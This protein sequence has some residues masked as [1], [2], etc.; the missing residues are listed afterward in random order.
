MSPAIRRATG[1]DAQAL[2]DIGRRSFVEA[3][4]HLYGAEDLEAF[5]K[6]SHA[7]DVYARYLADPAYALWLLDD[8]GHVVGYAL[9]GPAGLPHPEVTSADGELKRLYVLSAAQN[10]G[11]GGQL[12]QAAMDWLQ[13][14][15]PRS[16][17][18]SVWSE[19]LG[20]QRFY[21]RHG[22]AHA[23]EYEFRSGGCAIVSSSSGGARLRRGH[24]PTRRPAAWPV[25]ARR[26]DALVRV[27]TV[28]GRFCPEIFAYHGV[29]EGPE[30]A[31]SRLVA[32]LAEGGADIVAHSLGG[33][34]AL[35]ALCEAPQLG[36]RRVVCLGSPLTG[37]G[38]VAGMLRWAP[39]AAMFGRSAA[40]LQQGVQCWQGR[41]DVGVIAG[42]RAAWTGR[43]V[44]RVRRRT[45]R[46]VA[47]DETRLPGW[48]TTWWSMPATAGCCSRRGGG[49]GDRIP[50]RRALPRGVGGAPC[51]IA[52][53]GSH[54]APRR[55]AAV[56]SSRL[57]TPATL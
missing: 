45:R 4:G 47:V 26:I 46:H 8:G 23:G 21:A 44:R 20:A 43:V 30:T 7:P 34:I 9:A 56:D 5:L 16:L 18:I 3:F 22:F 12:F 27:E 6:E 28:G 51:G 54:R 52:A 49:T 37:S 41:A 32:L 31:V 17:W 39:A 19:N 40:L 2:C 1:A 29:V 53:G 55:A 42:P 57:I 33:L 14:E 24:E 48:P 15:G 50:A 38:A 36:V 25:D 13:R 10:S 35:Q 11:W